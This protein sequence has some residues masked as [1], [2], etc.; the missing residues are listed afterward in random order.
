MRMWLTL[1]FGWIEMIGYDRSA[2]NQESNLILLLS[3]T[4]GLH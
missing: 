1:T 2:F 3:S 4:N